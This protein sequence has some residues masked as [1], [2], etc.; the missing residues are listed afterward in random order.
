MSQL[1]DSNQNL[2]GM[3]FIIHDITERKKAEDLLIKSK[4]FNETV[5][6]SMNDAISVIDVNNFRIIDANSV[7]LENYGMKKEEVIGK[8]CYEITHKSVKPCSPP[9]DICPLMDTLNT[10]KHSTAEHVHY[11]KD[12]K[13]RYVEVLTSPIMDEN[14]KVVNVIHVSRD[15]TERKQ[16]EKTI[17]VSFKRLEEEKAKT[18][19]IIAA[20]GCA[21]SIQDPDFKVLYQNKIHQDIAG[22]QK[23]KYCY[24]EYE[25]RDHVCE[26]CPVKMSFKDGKI[27]TEER[28]I[29]KNGQKLYFEITSS[30]L[31]DSTGNIIAGIEVGRDITERKKAE[32]QI[33]NSLN[34]KE[35]LL[36]E[37]HHRVKNN[38][39]IISSL[40]LLQSQ[41]IDDKKYLDIFT[42]SNNRILSMALIHEKL[43]QSENLAQINIQE[44]I[45]DLASNL[46][47][48]YGGKGNAEL[49]I[50][51]ENI[52]L[53]INYAVPCGLILNELITNSLKYAF[54]EDRH[55]KIKIVFQKRDGNMIHFSVSDDGIGIPK[56][57]DIRNTKSLGMHLIYAL[58]ENQLH[59]EIILNR[60][61]G[62][63]FQINFKGE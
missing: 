30:P 2:T 16:A 38:M 57:I 10:G 62:T 37:I 21:I 61:R 15:I 59:G 40:L 50:N 33:A 22:D 14:G 54:P 23:G 29:I 13:K 63:E 25:H 32:E 28:S 6:N 55:G 45:N 24:R 47:G 11:M 34:E 53:N 5:I 43:Y 9:D 51:V 7:F 35:T 56:D 58:A 36:K 31:R 46:M 20:I 12:G 41:N 44:Y 60:E 48:S 8:T 26:D 1:L 17:E 52:P 49:E 39:Q 4:E 19:S 27:H 3:S 18:E 42:E